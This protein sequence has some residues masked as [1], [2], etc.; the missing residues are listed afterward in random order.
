MVCSMADR[1]KTWPAANSMACGK[2]YG[3]LTGIPALSPLN[4]FLASA[5]VHAAVAV[6]ATDGTAV[7]AALPPGVAQAVPQATLSV[8]VF[9]EHSFRQPRQ[10][11]YTAHGLWHGICPIEFSM[12]YGLWPLA[13][14]MTWPMA[15]PMAAKAAILCGLRPLA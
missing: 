11:T 6:G 10:P 1:K 9:D 2:S 3:Q 5:I 14:P 4:A 13:W 8:P 7:G 15:C 12:S